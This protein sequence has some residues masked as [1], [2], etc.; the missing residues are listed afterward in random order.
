M[1][2]ANFAACLCLTLPIL[3]ASAQ[4]DNKDNSTSRVEVSSQRGLELKS[5]AQM[6]KGLKAYA[7]YNTLAPNSELFFILIPKSKNMGL[8]GV[9]MRLASDERSINIPI[10]A[11]GK[12]QL[13]DIALQHED[14]YDLILNKPKGQFYFK[15]Y[16]KSANLPD[17]AKRLGDIRLECQVRWAVEKQDVSI[18]FL[19]HVNLFASGNPCTSRAVNVMYFAPLD[20]KTVV[21]N[22]PKSKLEKKVNSN[23]QYNLPIWD[24]SII[25]DA[26]IHY[27]RE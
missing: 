9:T 4:D 17:D 22:T 26:L 5:Y 2:F 7:E 1:T 23:G 19:T 16:V 27:E 24:S 13:P 14:E 21:L 8:E 11:N 15:P 6:Q 25:D 3:T 10:D 12:F 18:V 20:V